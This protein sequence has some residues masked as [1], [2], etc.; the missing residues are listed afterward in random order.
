MKTVENPFKKLNFK[1]RLTLLYSKGQLSL[2]LLTVM[3]L[4]LVI[5]SINRFRDAPLYKE[6][7]L[8]P[9]NL[10]PN[11]SQDYSSLATSFTINMILLTLTWI[12]LLL[13]FIAWF[14]RHTKIRTDAVIVY[15]LVGFFI[16]SILYMTFS[17][18][19][20]VRVNTLLENQACQI[21]S[22]CTI[23]VNEEVLLEDLGVNVNENFFEIQT[24]FL[25]M[26]FFTVLSTLQLIIDRVRKLII[27]TRIK[28]KQHDPTTI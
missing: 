11:M 14:L 22:E 16:A 27:F 28:E 20:F 17:Q 9:F 6:L 7:S 3:L 12:I 4:T 26:I 5:I 19:L 1:Q 10:N 13:Y 24:A 25:A 21:D 2:L 15:S 8:I 18:P 23:E